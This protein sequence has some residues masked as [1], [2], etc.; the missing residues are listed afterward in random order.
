MEEKTKKTQDN[1]MEQDQSQ[2]MYSIS[3]EFKVFVQKTLG[4]RPY[5]QVFKFIG[6]IQKDKLNENEVNV[7][8]NEMSKLPY[9]EVFEF[10]VNLK[11]LVTKIDDNETTKKKNN[12]K[13]N[14]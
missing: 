1:T 2:N 13:E 9:N 12:K 6:L 14:K 5:G 7:I 3:E 4:Q 11:N 8:I 10:F